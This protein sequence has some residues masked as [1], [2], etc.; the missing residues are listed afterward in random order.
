MSE[1]SGRLNEGRWRSAA[2]LG[3]VVALVIG[4]RLIELPKICV[5]ERA[6]FVESHVRSL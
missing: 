4:Y 2:A 1:C 3:H 5:S 6:D